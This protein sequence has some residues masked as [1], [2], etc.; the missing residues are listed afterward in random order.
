L[1]KA[2]YF[3]YLFSIGGIGFIIF[4]LGLHLINCT[5]QQ[6]AIIQIINLIAFGGSALLYLKVQ[7]KIEGNEAIFL[8][9]TFAI[10]FILIGISFVFIKNMFPL[11][12][13][14]PYFLFLISYFLFLGYDITYKVKTLKKKMLD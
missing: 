13:H 6:I 4:S 1:I 10:K 7:K 12:N 9:F 3:K 8:I 11:S 2:D 5:Y 14:S